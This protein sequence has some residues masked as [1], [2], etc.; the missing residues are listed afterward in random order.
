MSYINK[1][2][3][4]SIKS[5]S[6]QFCSI[7]TI[8]TMSVKLCLYLF[9]HRCKCLRSLQSTSSVPEQQTSVNFSVFHCVHL[10]RAER[11][12]MLTVDGDIAA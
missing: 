12:V 10:V 5:S 11:S 1:Q 9:S 4:W 6:R 3:P 2:L 7:K 8:H